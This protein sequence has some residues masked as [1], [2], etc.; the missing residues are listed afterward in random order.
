MGGGGDSI[1]GLNRTE[2]FI[3]CDVTAATVPKD[4]KKTDQIKMI[5]NKNVKHNTKLNKII[6]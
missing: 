5:K 4:L 1:T 6:I 3:M 2:T